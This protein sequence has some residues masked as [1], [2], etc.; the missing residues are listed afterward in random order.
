MLTVRGSI[1][2]AALTY[3]WWC[4]VCGPYDHRTDR[5]HSFRFRSAA[6]RDHSAAR[7]WPDHLVETFTTAPDGRRLGNPVYVGVPGMEPAR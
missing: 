4:T 3:H 7:H 1:P 5:V 2:G 6:D